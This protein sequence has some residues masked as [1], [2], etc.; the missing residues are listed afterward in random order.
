MALLPLLG[1]FRTSAYLSSSKA[2]TYYTSH[3]LWRYCMKHPEVRDICDA[4]FALTGKR[5]AW[6]AAFVGLAL[7]NWAIMGLHVNA[8]ATAIQTIRG[9]T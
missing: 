5:Y 7:N 4:A 3:V 2:S 1:Q 9:G 8:G 6:W